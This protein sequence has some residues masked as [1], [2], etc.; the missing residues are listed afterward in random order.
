[1][2]SREKVGRWP[3]W[4][5]PNKCVENLFEGA[6]ILFCNYIFTKYQD[7]DR[8]SISKSISTHFSTKPSL[9]CRTI[10]SSFFPTYWV[11]LSMDLV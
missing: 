10:Q 9:F 6:L 2:T 7:K 5:S 8:N 11:K 3:S 1:M 4:A